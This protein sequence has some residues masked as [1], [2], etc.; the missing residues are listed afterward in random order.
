[1]G[2]SERQLLTLLLPPLAGVT[3][4]MRQTEGIRSVYPLLV[5]VTGGQSLQLLEREPLMLFVFSECTQLREF[6]CSSSHAL[7]CEFQEHCE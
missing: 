7:K 5:F 6:V 3:L 4:E 1:M 2:P